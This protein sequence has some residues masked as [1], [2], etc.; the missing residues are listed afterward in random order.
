MPGAARRRPLVSPFSIALVAAWR[1]PRVT[2]LRP[3]SFLPR[4]SSASHQRTATQ[5]Q[6]DPRRTRIGPRH[7]GRLVK[8]LQNDETLY[9]LNA[10]KLMMPASTQ[11]I[12]TLAVAADQLGWDYT[13]RTSVAHDR[14][15]RKRRPQRGRRGGRIGRSN[16]RRLGW[17]RDRTIRGMGGR[18]EAAGHS[19]NRRSDHW[20][21]QRVRRR[22]AWTGMGVGRS[23]GQL[24][25]RCRG[26]A[27]QSEHRPA[28]R[29]AI[30]TWRTS[31]CAGNA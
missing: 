28:R 4:Q 8:S 10:H 3:R 16:L 7:V 14:F 22:G 12:L 11:K 27:V 9:T 18:I 1:S 17:I 5:H 21:R 20:R 23:R 29:H 30:G 2:P 25:D 26:P 19:E 24:R 15:D 6:H 13:Y 31:A